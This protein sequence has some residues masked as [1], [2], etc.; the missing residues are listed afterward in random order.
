MQCGTNQKD[1]YIRR[2][3]TVWRLILK[4]QVNMA[5]QSGIEKFFW[6]VSTLFKDLCLVVS[7]QTNHTLT[8]LDSIERLLFPIR[9]FPHWAHD[10][11]SFVGASVVGQ[12]YSVQ[13]K[14]I[15]GV[16]DKVRHWSVPK[17]K[18]SVYAT[19]NS[20]LIWLNLTLISV[21]STQISV[22]W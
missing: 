9:F 15:F 18:L 20:C 8:S 2:V 21:K 22:D 19:P 7:I 5:K 10:D 14:G 11:S 17:I 6:H 4:E 12:L 1:I 16:P 3:K 13:Y